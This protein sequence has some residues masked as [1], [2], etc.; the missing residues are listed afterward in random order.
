MLMEGSP[1]IHVGEETFVAKARRKLVACEGFG[2]RDIPNV[3]KHH[4]RLKEIFRPCRKIENKVEVYMKRHGL[5]QGAVLVGFH[6]RRGDY[7]TYRN[8]EYFFND[9]SWIAW[10][11]QARSLFNANGRRFVGLIFSNE[12]VESVINSGAD[13][14]LGPGDM[15]EDLHMLSKCHYLVGPPSTFSGWAS[16]VGRVPVRY[17]TKPDA[18]SELG[19]FRIVEW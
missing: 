14:I 11:N 15:Y 18:R 7:R 2:F 6:I 17:V 4:Q 19:D 5:E 3:K 9:E 1:Y 8:G 16:Y 13:L 12:K 10:I